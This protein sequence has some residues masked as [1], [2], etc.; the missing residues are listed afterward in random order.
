[1]TA[2]KICHLG[3]EQTGRPGKQRA[4]R[5]KGVTRQLA[6]GGR[7]SKKASTV[8]ATEIKF[9]RCLSPEKFRV[10]TL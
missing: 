8:R 2:D 1:M 10:I 5:Q 4:A 3:A 6:H 9:I 7:E